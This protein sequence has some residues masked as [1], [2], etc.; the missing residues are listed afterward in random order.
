L[1]CIQHKWESVEVCNTFYHDCLGPHHCV[2]EDALHSHYDSIPIATAVSV[3]SAPPVSTLAAI[4][5]PTA[6][7]ATGHPE[8][9]VT[10]DLGRNPVQM[11]CP[12][13][14]KNIATRTKTF[15]N[16]LTW[17]AVAGVTVIFWP[18]FFVPLVID[19]VS[20]YYSCYRFILVQCFLLFFRLKICVASSRR[21]KRNIIVLTVTK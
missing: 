16:W 12:H 9:P 18:V 20:V 6:P 4:S 17:F 1:I 11:I 15:P 13:C 7:A 3:P 14:N 2:S 19:Q 21:K 5:V 10:F 8:L